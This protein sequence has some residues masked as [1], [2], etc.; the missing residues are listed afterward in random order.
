M[1]QI[2]AAASVPRPTLPPKGA[3]VAT[4]SAPPSAPPAFPKTDIQQHAATSQDEQPSASLPTAQSHHHSMHARDDTGLQRADEGPITERPLGASAVSSSPQ[5]TN[6]QSV[7][8]VAARQEEP[9]E[10]RSKPS[11]VSM[12]Q[13]EAVSMQQDASTAE[14]DQATLVPS[15]AWPD[16]ATPLASTSHVDTV[17]PQP[18]TDGKA[19]KGSK[20]QK[21]SKEAKEKSSRGK[22]KESSKSKHGKKDKRSSRGGRQ[23]STSRS[24]SPKRYGPQPFLLSVSM[25][26]GTSVVP[27]SV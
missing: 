26:Y 5:Q 21:D 1:Q 6:S 11:T 8:A 2:K 25:Q 22:E 24:R 7:K 14:P 18:I 17:G 13:P 27:T 19:V 20:G 12:D 10:S 4:P 3:K 15:T 9:E 16:Q 23:R